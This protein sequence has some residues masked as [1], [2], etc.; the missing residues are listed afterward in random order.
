MAALPRVQYAL[1]AEGLMLPDAQV[2]Y[3]MKA[4]EH[5]L[6]WRKYMREAD[7]LLYMYQ[8]NFSMPAWSGSQ[9]TLKIVQ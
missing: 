6:D 5:W 3:Y 2:L 7:T 8:N 4:K 9:P 1:R